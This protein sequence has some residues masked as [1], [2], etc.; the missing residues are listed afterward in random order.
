MVGQVVRIFPA[1]DGEEEL[2]LLVRRK[3]GGGAI[4]GFCTE[5]LR[6]MLG[7]QIFFGKNGPN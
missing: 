4:Q 6:A 5:N 1:L 7:A 2:E 3:S